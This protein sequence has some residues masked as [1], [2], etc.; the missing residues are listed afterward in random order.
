M[1]FL[2]GVWLSPAEEAE[3]DV[4]WEGTFKQSPGTELTKVLFSG[5]QARE[6][7]SMVKQGSGHG[8][9]HSCQDRRKVKGQHQEFV[10]ARES[11]VDSPAS[12]IGKVTQIEH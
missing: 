2:S 10:R 8:H 7:E 4:T 12:R 5:G 11:Y 3:A 6:P 9:E 1:R